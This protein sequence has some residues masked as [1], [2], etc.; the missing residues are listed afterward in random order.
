MS[1]ASSPVR[2]LVAGLSMGVAAIALAAP[3]I[4]SAADYVAMGD[5]YSSGTGTRDYYD[6]TCERSN[7]SYSKLIDPQIPGNLFLA[8]CG[9]EADSPP[10]AGLRA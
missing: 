7:F 4:S 10:Q 3:A 2:R 8:A 6:A 1:R 9:G 5:S